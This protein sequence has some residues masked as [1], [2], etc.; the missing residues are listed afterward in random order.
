M[1]EMKDVTGYIVI[2]P[3]ESPVE[4]IDIE[5]VIATAKIEAKKHQG[6]IIQVCCRLDTYISDDGETVH[7]FFDMEE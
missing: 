4:C 3:N 6:E 5:D 2:I 1:K 7:Q